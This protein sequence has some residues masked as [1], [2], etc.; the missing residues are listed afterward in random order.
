MFSV[1]E[2][3]TVEML[4]FQE[5]QFS[6][7]HDGVM[8]LHP[9]T[10]DTINYFV[11]TSTD[12]ITFTNTAVTFDVEPPTTELDVY[13][14]I[15][16]GGVHHFQSNRPLAGFVDK[17]TS[18]DGFD[19][20][21]VGTFD[22]TDPGMYHGPCTSAVFMFN[23]ANTFFTSGGI[24]ST[25]DGETWS[26]DAPTYDLSILT[27]G[28]YTITS[29][30]FTGTDILFLATSSNLPQVETRLFRIASGSYIA[31]SVSDD[32]LQLW[33]GQYPTLL[34]SFNDATVTH[35]GV[36]LDENN[37]EIYTGSVS[38]LQVDMGDFVFNSSGVGMLNVDMGDIGFNTGSIGL[39]NVDMGE[40]TFNDYATG[41]L[42]VDL[43]NPIPPVPGAARTYD[44]FL[45]F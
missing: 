13:Y 28:L 26:I 4:P 22:I 30:L 2:A 25:T 36:F 11:L 23:G 3:F 35:I 31:E 41:L 8:W 5:G 12:G 34:M 1:D 43:G 21:F 40:Y 33:N 10:D 17:Y 19:Y 38:N 44:M 27:P 7:T 42:N 14:C 24:V 9:H 39:L 29:I 20:T 16:S 37:F 32:L 45:V 18:T 6:T 15:D